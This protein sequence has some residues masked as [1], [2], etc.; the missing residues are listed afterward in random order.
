MTDFGEVTDY[1][2]GVTIRPAT[3]AEWRRTA[4][5]TNSGGL[6]AYTGAWEEKG[7]AVYVDGGPDM[8][9]TLKD[10]ARLGREAAAAGDTEQA[11]MCAHAITGHEEAMAGCVKVILDNRMQ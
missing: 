9:V 3:A 8:D 10:V 4:D 11:G 6:G 5:V 2:S 1:F 7:I